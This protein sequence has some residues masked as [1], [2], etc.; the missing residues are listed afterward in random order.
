MPKLVPVKLDDNTIIFIESTEDATAPSVAPP[1]PSEEEETPVT[2]GGRFSADDVQDQVVQNFKA[3]EGTIRAYTTYTLNAFRNLA[4][5]NID[6]VTLKFGIEI[7]GEAG[8]PYV[9]KG[10]A[11]SNLNIEVVCSFPQQLEN[12]SK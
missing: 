6:T 1:E 3:I 12:Q 5:A 9:T 2:R 4:I 8:I 10:T 7:G 11:K